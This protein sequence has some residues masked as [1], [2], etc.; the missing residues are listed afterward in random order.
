MTYWER[1]KDKYKEANSAPPAFF[2]MLKVAYA[3]EVQP[4]DIEGI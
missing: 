1:A 2:L 4:H 3:F